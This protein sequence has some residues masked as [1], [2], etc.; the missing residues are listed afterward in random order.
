MRLILITD[1]GATKADWRLLRPDGTAVAQVLTPGMNVSAMSTGAVREIIAV[2]AREL[3]GYPAPAEIH[4]YTA[5][6]ISEAIRKELTEALG[7]IGGASE[8]EIETDLIGAARAACGHSPGVAAILGTGSNAMLY[9]G[10]GIVRRINSGG[11]ILGDQGSAATLGRLFLSDLIKGR[12]PEHISGELSGIMDISYASIVDK[13]YHGDAPSGFLGSLAPFIVSHYDDPY[14]KS[15][16]D[17][18]FQSFI[19]LS[20][21][22]LCGAGLPA[23]IVGGFGCACRHIFGPLAEASGIS[24][25]KYIP[26]PVDGLIAYHCG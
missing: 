20:L 10:S 23:G 21:K 12:V 16:V 3:S 11:Y 4:F 17:G 2:A 6:I 19:D 26:E 8:T 25:T 7:A 5:G 14:I 1:S 13:V 15:L 9:D 22:P 24:V 18:N